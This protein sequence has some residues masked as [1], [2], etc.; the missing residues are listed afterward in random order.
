[1]FIFVVASSF[2]PY[3]VLSLKL[4]CLVV[5]FAK[6]ENWREPSSVRCLWQ[7]FLSLFLKVC[8][9][10][11]GVFFTCWLCRMSIPKSPHWPGKFLKEH[12]KDIK[13]QFLGRLLNLCFTLVQNELVKLLK[14]KY[15]QYSGI[16]TGVNLFLLI[17]NIVTIQ[18]VL[19]LLSIE[20]YCIWTVN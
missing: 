10:I 3:F 2:R 4:R 12:K 14:Y 5:F 18:R 6:Q 16:I 1:M 9:H 7:Y 11:F 13:K 19:R 17:L 15:I 8:R 20:Q